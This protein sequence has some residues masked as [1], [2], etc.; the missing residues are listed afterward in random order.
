ASA[1]WRAIEPTLGVNQAPESLLR[2]IR[3]YGLLDDDEST[4]RL[5]S[6]LSSNDP[7]LVLLAIDI[8]AA[9]RRPESLERLTRLRGHPSYETHYALRHAVISAVARFDE[10][11]SVDFLIGAVTSLDGQLKY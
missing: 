7:R 11:A 1:I 8:L 2:A 6:L 3:I 9:Q 10:P 5:G 4:G